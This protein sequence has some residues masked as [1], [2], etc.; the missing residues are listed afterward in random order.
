IDRAQGTVVLDHEDRG[1]SLDGLE[2]LGVDLS[3]NVM[4][5]P[6][7][8]DYHTPKL[9]EVLKAIGNPPVA[10]KNSRVQP[11]TGLETKARVSKGAE[12]TLADFLWRGA[13]MSQEPTPRDL[14]PIRNALEAAGLRLNPSQWRAWATALHQRLSLIWGPPGTGK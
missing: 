12:P 13:M 3:D 7:F 1:I 14:G 11:A 4:L 10:V 9:R 6:T 8:R 2:D 5:D